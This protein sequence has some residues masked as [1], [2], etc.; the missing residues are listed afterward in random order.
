MLCIPAIRFEALE[1]FATS[2]VAYT[3]DVPA[4][5]GS[6]GKPLLIGPG[7]IHV[8]H[9]N[10]ERVAKRELVESSQI[11]QRIVRELLAANAKDAGAAAGS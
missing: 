10:E 8:A 2:I 3:T 9:T 11:Y 4:F 6:W 1:G 7:N 5:D